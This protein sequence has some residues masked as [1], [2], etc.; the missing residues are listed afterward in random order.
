MPVVTAAYTNF[1]SYRR[2]LVSSASQAASLVMAIGVIELRFDSLFEC[3]E[4]TGCSM[5]LVAVSPR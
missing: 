1:P 5:L 2:S 4:S 3:V